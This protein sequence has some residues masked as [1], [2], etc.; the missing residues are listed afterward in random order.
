MGGNLPVG[1]PGLP[2]HAAQA[3]VS[4]DDTRSVGGD[5]QMMLGIS[6]RQEKDIAS[7]DRFVSRLQTRSHGKIEP[8]I[9][10]HIAQPVTPG[11]HRMRSGRG[12]GVPDHTNAIEAGGRVPSMQ[13][14]AASDKTKRCRSDSVPA[15]GH[16]WP[17]RARRSFPGRNGSP[18]KLAALAKRAAQVAM[19]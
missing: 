4:M 9:N 10:G 19:V 13:A 8:G 12:Q 7:A 2:D 14:E 11:G 16:G 5:H 6:K 15:Q 3:R 17:Y 1:L 18:R